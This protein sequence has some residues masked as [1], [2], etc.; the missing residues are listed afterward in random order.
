M[1][2]H[3]IQLACNI[4]AMSVSLGV[5]F[6]FTRSEQ[7]IMEITGAAWLIMLAAIIA[8]IFGVS[9]L[10]H[11]LQA[12]CG[13]GTTGKI[14]NFLTR[15]VGLAMI[16]PVGYLI[17]TW[18]CPDNVISNDPLTG[19]ALAASLSTANVISQGLEELFVPTRY[20]RK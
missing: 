7:R 1:K 11:Y 6:L 13:A 17:A 2:R 9:F 14:V 20:E 4:P 19:F 16:F 8:G 12:C 15:L 18:L 10:S 3:A 5:V